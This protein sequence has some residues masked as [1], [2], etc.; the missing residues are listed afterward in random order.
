[1]ASAVTYQEIVK[2][3]HVFVSASLPQ[4]PHQND[5]RAEQ[6]VHR[7]SAWGRDMPV[8]AVQIDLND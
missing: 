2:N 7:L 4:M 3:V 5:K 6:F 1:M 8:A